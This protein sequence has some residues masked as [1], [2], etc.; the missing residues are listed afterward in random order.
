MIPAEDF[1]VVKMKVLSY[2]EPL[3]ADLAREALDVV[4]VFRGPHH[5]FE[6]R[7]WLATRRANTRNTKQPKERTIR[8]ITFVNRG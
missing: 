3:S 8:T 2:S 1:V 5:K 6:R 4:G 7:N